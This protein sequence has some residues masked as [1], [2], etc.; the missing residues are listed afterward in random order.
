M[1]SFDAGSVVEGLEWNFTTLPGYPDRKAKGTVPEP[2]DATIG[3]FLD[4]L[5]KL[6]EEAQQL[7]AAGDVDG[8]PEQMLEAL[9]SVTGDAFVDFM[10]KTAELFSDLCGN[11][12][13]KEQ[14]LALP[15]RVR[16]QFYGWLQGEVVNPEAGPGGGTAVVRSLPTA[17]AG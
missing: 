17:A 4:G 11:K 16:A 10:A 9:S 12:P 7:G 3:R 1:P 8:S 6:Y 5:K 14:L 15:L 2:S 13:T